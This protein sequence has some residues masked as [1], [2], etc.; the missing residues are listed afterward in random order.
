MSTVPNPVSQW[1]ETPDANPATSILRYGWV[2][3]A[4]TSTWTLTG[5]RREHNGEL[6]DV[7]GTGTFALELLGVGAADDARLIAARRAGAILF[8]EGTS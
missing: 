8:Y 2:Y 1:H 6:V 3:D 5:D 7:G 4:G